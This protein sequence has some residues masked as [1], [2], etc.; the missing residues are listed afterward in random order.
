MQFSGPLQ[1]SKFSASPCQCRPQMPWPKQQWPCRCR[2]PPPPCPARHHW[3]KAKTKATISLHCFCHCCLQGERWRK[4]DGHN[5]DNIAGVQSWQ[6]Q[7]Q[8]DFCRRLMRIN[9]LMHPMLQWWRLT[10]GSGLATAS[11]DARYIIRSSAAFDIMQLLTLL[12]SA[13]VPY[14]W[15]LTA[16]VL[17][18]FFLPSITIAAPVDSWLLCSL[19]YLYSSVPTEPPIWKVFMFSHLD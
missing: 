13:D 19:S 11:A 2:T 7:R 8:A 18:L 3:R 9:R 15:P 16:A 4:G 6:R 5:W 10:W 1:A 14:C 17:F 12:L